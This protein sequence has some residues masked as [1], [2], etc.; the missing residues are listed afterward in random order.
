M[1]HFYKDY[2]VER[3][4]IGKPDSSWVQPGDKRVQVGFITPKD[5]RA[6]NVV[7]K[8]GDG[9][10]VVFPIDYKVDRQTYIINNLNEQSYVFNL[11]TKSED[12][13]L[14]LPTE[15]STTVY[16]DNFRL[17][18]KD[19]ELSHTVVFPD[20][21]AIIWKP[22]SVDYLFGSE[23]EYQDKAGAIKKVMVRPNTNISILKDVDTSKDMIVK[24]AF[25]PNEKAFEY[26]YTPSLAVN[27]VNS[28]RR[29]LK[30]V[31]TAYTDAEFIDFKY[32]R[33][34]LESAIPGPFG[35]D[36][37]LCYTLGGSSRSNLITI[38]GTGFSAFATAWQSN[39]GVWGVR[40]VGRLKVLKGAAAVSMY[41][42]LDETNRSQMAA[43]YTN[44]IAT[45]AN[46]VFPLA[47]D[48]I[49]LL[50]SSDRKIYVAMRVTAT[51]SSTAGV[52]GTLSFDFK[53]SRL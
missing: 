43:A 37:D 26:F 40:N 35:K 4:Y 12:G 31:S 22:L 6:K 34:F 2:I 5:T 36:I 32:V 20:S 53:V 44:G 9:D 50:N 7:V 14:S 24:T 39:I 49:V 16:G 45:E 28:Q 23:V 41:N 19:R 15:L 1:D 10:S 11:F 51:P 48:D 46:R 33:V 3:D 13:L 30:L 42:N 21:V 25:L 38:D 27:T 47:V 52:Y 17:S 18:M 29:S 8:W